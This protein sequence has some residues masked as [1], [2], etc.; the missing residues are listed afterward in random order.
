[1]EK[2]GK[3]IAAGLNVSRY[4][5]YIPNEGWLS[6]VGKDTYCYDKEIEHAQTFRAREDAEK[7]ADLSGGAVRILYRHKNQYITQP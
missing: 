2:A 3:F 6:Y 7:A 1:M 5:V 4:V